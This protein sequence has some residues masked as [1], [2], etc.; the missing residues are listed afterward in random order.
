MVE[1]AKVADPAA[2]LL[3][4]RQENSRRLSYMP[5]HWEGGNDA[6]GALD[7]DPAKALA[8]AQ[9]QLKANPL[10]IDAN[11][12][13][14]IAFAKMGRKEDETRQHTLLMALLRSVMDGKD[15]RTPQTAWNAVNVSEEYQVL[16]LI[17]MEPKRQALVTDA[18]KTFDA[19]TVELREPGQEATIHFNIDFF[20]GKEFGLGL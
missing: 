3:W 11:L 16:R 19:M 8:L 1:K 7:Q 6:F 18:G 17:G 2:D 9:K 5:P 20:F 15:G 10:D 14:E 13:A 12:L 4:L